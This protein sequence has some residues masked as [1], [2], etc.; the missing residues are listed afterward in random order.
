MNV[1]IEILMAYCRA[2]GEDAQSLVQDAAE[3]AA[4]Y[5][6][7]MGADINSPVYV[8][9]Y[10]ALTVQFFEHPEGGQFAPALTKL[11]NTLK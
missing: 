11:L 1:P 8:R 5:L 10:K 9:A 4:A 6:A 2:D 7:N 3:D